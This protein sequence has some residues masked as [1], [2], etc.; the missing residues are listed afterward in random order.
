MIQHVY[1]LV[2]PRAGG[3][4]TRQR[5][6]R[7]TP[8]LESRGFTATVLTSMR[9][10]NITTLA[11]TIPAGNAAAVVVGGDGTIREAAIGLAGR[12]IPVLAIPCGTENLLSRLYR[13]RADPD[14][15]ADTLRAAQIDLIDLCEANGLTFVTSAGCGFDAEVVRRVTAARNGHITRL[16]YLQPIVRTFFEHR[17]PRLHVEADGRQVFAGHG[18]AVLANLPSYALRLGLHPRATG[19]DGLIDLCVFECSG[20][21]GL[22]RHTCNVLR[23]IH[24]GSRGVYYGQHAY[25]RID[26]P[27]RVPLQLDGD[28]AGF[29]PVEIRVL[30]RRLPLLLPPNR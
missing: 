18:F 22:V 21:V 5:V 6:A 9:G 26:S 4:A 16:N 19:N 12:D 13:Y 10:A 28:V 8:T 3:A 27:Q 14:A 2:N 11:Q 17:Y 30:P 29:L 24:L 7:L 15:V 20:R 1:I 23:R 25:V